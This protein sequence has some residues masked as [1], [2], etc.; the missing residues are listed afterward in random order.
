V[1][2]R[3]AEEAQADAQQRELDVLL[4]TQKHVLADPESSDEDKAFARKILGL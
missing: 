3:K 2:W 1:I 4:E